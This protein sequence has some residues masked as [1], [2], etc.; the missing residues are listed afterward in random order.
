MRP[1]CRCC[2]TPASTRMRQLW[3]VCKRS[4]QNTRY[5]QGCGLLVVLCA[6]ISFGAVWLQTSTPMDAVVH[7]GVLFKTYT[8]QGSAKHAK[9]ALR[10]P[11][12]RKRKNTEERTSSQGTP[13]GTL[14]GITRAGKRLKTATGLFIIACVAGFVALT[15]LHM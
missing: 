2:T 5:V 6:R 10:G 14:T 9:A 3:N 15:R 13:S 11:S 7:S 12:V 1:A 8:V 4:D